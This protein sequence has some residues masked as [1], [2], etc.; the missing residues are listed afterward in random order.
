MNERCIHDGTGH[1][2]KERLE[3]VLVPFIADLANRTIFFFRSALAEILKSL[4][5]AGS[6]HRNYKYDC[7]E[8]LYV[9]RNDIV[10]D[11]N[12]NC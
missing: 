11:S 12:Q 7:N 3:N 5:E 4:D 1:E 9:Y 10:H 2:N 6:F 8:S